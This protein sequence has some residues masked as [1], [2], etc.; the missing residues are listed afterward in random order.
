MTTDAAYGHLTPGNKK[1]AAIQ[2]WKDQQNA[3]KV[4]FSYGPEKPLLYT[5]TDLKFSIQDLKT[6]NHLKDLVMNSTI[7]KD[8]KIFFKFN[9]V[10][11]K[12]GDLSLKAQFP[13]DGN[14]QIISQVRSKDNVA[15]ALTSFNIFVP[16]Q[17]FGKF[18]AD[19]FTTTLIPAGLVAVS[20]L[21]LVAVIMFVSKKKNSKRKPA[22]E[23]GDE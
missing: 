11:I 5:S 3:V 8:D 19:S 16:L 15:I 9:G 12:N 20:L 1:L 6:G 18:D 21:G 13:E 7:I 23:K 14:Y 10:T 17:P 2:E 22:D 4:L